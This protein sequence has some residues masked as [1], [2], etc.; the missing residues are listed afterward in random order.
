M[1]DPKDTSPAANDGKYEFQ[2]Y[3]SGRDLSCKVEKEQNIMHVFID[4]NINAELE[5]QPDGNV[6]QIEGN[7]LPDSSIEF[8]KKHVLEQH[9]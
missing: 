5:I 1:I 9:P 2:I 7:E 3:F 8:I 4:N 6:I